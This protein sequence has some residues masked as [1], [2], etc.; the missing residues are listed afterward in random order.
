MKSRGHVAPEAM[1][2]SVV[3]SGSGDLPVFLPAV[4]PVFPFP[5]FFLSSL[6]SLGLG[7]LWMATRW[8]QGTGER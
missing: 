8:R 2:C 4:A 7:V 1:L 3:R 6:F 5:P